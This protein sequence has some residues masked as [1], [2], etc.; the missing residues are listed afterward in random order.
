MPLTPDVDVEHL[1][2]HRARV[3]AD[4]EAT[5]ARIADLEANG[6]PETGEGDEDEPHRMKREAREAAA[7]SAP[8]TAVREPA[9]ERAVRP[10]PATKR[11]KAK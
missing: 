1:R 8:E 10:K 2:D 3:V 9:P 7:Q 6:H 5:D 11:K 4:L